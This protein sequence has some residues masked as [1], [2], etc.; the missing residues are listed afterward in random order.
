MHSG[1]RFL[2]LA[3]GLTAC[4]G[5]T[6]AAPSGTAPTPEP[7]S[8]LGPFQLGMSAVDLRLACAESDGRD[9]LPN[10]HAFTRGCE[11]TVDVDGITFQRFEM[12][13]DGPAGN[14]MRIRGHAEHA[15]AHRAA[16][17][18]PGADIVVVEDVVLVTV[19]APSAAAATP[20]PSEAARPPE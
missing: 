3:L 17:A 12:R 14:L 20:A 18:F 4:A 2:P 1:L 11:V 8:G 10:R 6:A 9:W 7:V 15:D 19:E 13:L 5:T 16:E